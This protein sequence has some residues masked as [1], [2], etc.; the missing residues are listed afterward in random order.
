MDKKDKPEIVISTTQDQNSPD[1]ALMV[2]MG[3]LPPNLN[4]EEIISTLNLKNKI[5]N[6]QLKIAKNSSSSSFATFQCLDH[7]LYKK[8][9]TP[10]GKAITLKGRKI[11]TRKFFKNFEKTEI[12]NLN[13]KR[14]F[15]KKVPL[16]FS[17]GI[18]IWLCELYE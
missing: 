17:D 7:E 6:F 2:F 18:W 3:C 14:V 5:K 9:T 4:E 11:P 15:L 16:K 8:F 13:R 10:G 12:E 1:P